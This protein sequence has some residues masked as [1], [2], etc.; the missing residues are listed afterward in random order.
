[1]A[2]R[3]AA[4]SLVDAAEHGAREIGDEAV[5]LA[6]HAPTVVARA[7]DAGA[8]LAES[9]GATAIVMD[10]GLQNPSLAKDFVLC[11]GGRRNRNRQRT[12]LAGRTHCARHWRRN[13][14]SCRPW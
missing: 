9:A 8:R 14:V 13:G 3:G 11:D 2:E 7:R 4:P 10:D 1:M 12:M 6:R 5:L